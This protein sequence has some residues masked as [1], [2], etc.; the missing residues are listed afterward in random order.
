M[1]HSEYYSTKEVAEQINRS[2][3]TVHAYVQEGKLKPVEDPWGGHQG[4]LFSKEEIERLIETMPKT[5]EG[6]TLNQAAEYLQ[7][8]RNFIAAYIKEGLLPASEG[9]VKG[10]TIPLI[11]ESDLKEFSELYEKRIWEDRLSQRQ[12]Y[13]KK[14]K[15]AVYQR[16]SSPSIPEAR[17]MRKG[18]GDWYFIVPGTDDTFSYMEGIYTHRL[19]PDYSIEMGKRSTKPGYAVLNLPAVYSLTYQVMDLLYQQVPVANLYM[20]RLKDRWI[21]HMK[22]ARFNGVSVELADFIKRS[23]KQGRVRYVP[24]YEGISI[25]SQEELLSV[26][27]SVDIKDWLR[28]KGEQTGKS[29]QDIAAE[30]LEEVHKREQGQSNH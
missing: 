7:T 6:L 30:I 17:L 23:A 29:M 1:Q 28:K 21:I 26:S 12:Y 15:E 16:F 24:E 19:T 14:A 11:T 10:R 2:V 25:E 3:S 20:E 13:N 22:D 27:L 8:N 5:P 18:L 9:Q 4:L